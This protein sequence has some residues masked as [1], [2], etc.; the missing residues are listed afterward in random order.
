MVGVFSIAGN[1]GPNSVGLQFAKAVAKAFGPARKPDYP[2]AGAGKLK[3]CEQEDNATR[4]DSFNV[5]ITNHLYII[6]SFIPFDVGPVN[7]NGLDAASYHAPGS[8]NGSDLGFE[9][10][11]IKSGL[12]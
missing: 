7:S 8:C 10:P 3:R 12:R 2:A 5:Y 9:L 4:N 6:Y 1:V 11:S